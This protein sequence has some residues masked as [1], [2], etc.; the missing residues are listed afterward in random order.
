MTSVSKEHEISM[1]AGA[2]VA[3]AS[4]KFARDHDRATSTTVPLHAYAIARTALFAGLNE[5]ELGV[6]TRKAKLERFEP[7]RC[8]W[9]PEQRAR[10]FHIIVRGSLKL[11]HPLTNGRLALL[12]IFGPFDSIGDVAAIYDM[13]YP[14]HACAITAGELLRIPREIP[15]E[16]A[17]TN[18][19]LKRRFDLAPYAHL[20]RLQSAVATLHGGTVDARLAS[21][22]LD[23]TDRLGKQQANESWIVPVPL[24]RSDLADAISA[25]IETTIRTMVRWQKRNIVET[26]TTG[27]VIHDRSAL[28]DIAVRGMN[29]VG[30]V[31]AT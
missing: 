13:P 24:S 22:L 1:S 11:C 31:S 4:A 6:L 18:E 12:S 14:A 29:A 9:T 25:R 7:G 23:I 30:H 27:F 5:D 15:L 21:M 20:A 10:S 28:E 16:I 8:F 17:K 2:R 3:C 26:I 19:T